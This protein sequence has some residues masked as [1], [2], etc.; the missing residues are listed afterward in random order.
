[1]VG[2]GANRMPLTKVHPILL[3]K[4]NNSEKSGGSSLLAQSRQMHSERMQSGGGGGG[5]G[6]VMIFH[7]PKNIFLRTWQCNFKRCELSFWAELYNSPAK[8]T[9]KPTSFFGFV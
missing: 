7:F 5:G 9:L 2:T 6:Q 8:I 1:M 3:G 4:Q